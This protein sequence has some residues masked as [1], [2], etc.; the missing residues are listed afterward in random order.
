M[1][2]NMKSLDKKWWAIIIAATVVVLAVGSFFIL[3]N[4]AY[5]TYLA[6]VEAHEKLDVDTAVECYQDVVAYPKLLGSFVEDAQ[7]KL[8]ETR[9][10][11]DASA[12]WADGH[13]AEAQEAFKTFIEDYPS[14]VFLGESQTAMMRIPFEWAGECTQ[15]EDYECAVDVY[16]GIVQDENMPDENVEEAKTLLFDVYTTWAANESQAGDFSSCE[17]LLLDLLSWTDANDSSKSKDVKVILSETYLDW[18]D[19]LYT[20]QDYGAALEKYVLS[21]AQ[22]VSRYTH[23]TEENIGSLYLDWGDELVQAGDLA[24]AGEKYGALILGY[25]ETDAFGEIPGR[26]AE[27]LLLFGEESLAAGEFADA[28]EIYTF[29]DSLL[30]DGQGELKAAARYG[31][32]R[33]YLG[34]GDYLKAVTAFDQALELTELESLKEDIQASRESAIE[35]IGQLDNYLGKS[36]IYAVSNDILGYKDYDPTCYTADGIKTCF[37]EE[38]MQLAYTAVG[39]DEDEKR[40]MLFIEGDGEKNYPLPDDMEA[41][42]PG[43][44]HYVAIVKETQRQVESCNYSKTGYRAVSHYLVRMQRIY[45]V[46][47]YDT[48]TGLVVDIGTLYGAEPMTCPRSYTFHAVTEHIIG[49]KPDMNEVVSWLRSYVK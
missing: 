49:S 29:A 22:D 13:Y 15:N 24:G 14:S 47:V 25:S 9:A 36:I 34:Q 37:T 32:G 38:E 10:Y 3:K 4:I 2:G 40:L 17:M 7:A 16:D 44:F 30:E 48:R 20:E 6:G 5:H 35:G 1:G 19:L 45:K 43:H 8:G 23:R 12:L 18:G 26:A 31:I 41:T 42:R 21:L 46:Y 39:Q 28:E 33:A 11:Q 27:P